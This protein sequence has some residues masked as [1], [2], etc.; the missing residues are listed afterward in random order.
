VRHQIPEELWKLD[1]N[2]I[3]V[4]ILLYL[5]SDAKLE[6]R[7]RGKRGDRGHPRHLWKSPRGLRLLYESF[8][9]TLPELL[10]IWPGY[11]RLSRRALGNSARNPGQHWPAKQ[12]SLWLPLLRVHPDGPLHDLNSLSPRRVDRPLL[13]HEQ[14]VC[15]LPKHDNVYFNR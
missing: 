4:L 15:L 14:S 5:F 12:Q 6:R 2:E 10:C 8:S 11:C 1:E 13:G 7:L 9:P 3:P